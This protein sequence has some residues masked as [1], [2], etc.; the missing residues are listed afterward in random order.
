[1]PISLRI[2]GY[3]EAVEAVEKAQA[4]AEEQLSKATLPISLN[5]LDIEMPQM[6]GFQ[7]L[8]VFSPSN[9]PIERSFNTRLSKKKIL[10]R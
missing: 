5:L 2:K 4:E 8:R 9:L 1:M 7:F 6:E 3:Q 10:T